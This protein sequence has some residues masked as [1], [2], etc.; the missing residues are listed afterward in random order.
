MKSFI[1]P[2][3]IVGFIGIAALIFSARPV[4]AENP[5]SSSA[6]SF[7]P[8]APQLTYAASNVLQ[9][10]Q[11]RVG[12]ETIVSYIRSSGLS[13]GNL[14]ASE[15][16]Y[17]HEQGISGGVITAMLDQQ[18]KLNDSAEQARAKQQGTAAAPASAPTVRAITA[19]QHQ[20]TYSPPQATYVQT[21]PNPNL[22]VMRDSSPRLVDY[23]IYPRFGNH[24]YPSY[25]Y[26]YN[27]CVS[28]SF[29]HRGGHFRSGYHASRFRGGCY[30]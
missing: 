18:K 5:T 30:Y 29:W 11:S 25:R 12:E 21:V 7:S 3:R 24:C 8:A 10:A 9:M 16:I 19:P 26:N 2:K 15:I 23:G 28:Y 20:Q 1:L 27:P 14:G 13:F 22:I 17:L 6:A 4:A